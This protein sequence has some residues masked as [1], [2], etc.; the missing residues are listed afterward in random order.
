MVGLNCNDHFYH[1][2]GELW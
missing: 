2:N 1:C